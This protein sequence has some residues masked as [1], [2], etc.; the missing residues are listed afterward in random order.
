VIVVR[1]GP[2]RYTPSGYVRTRYA[3]TE[4]DGIAVY[5]PD[6]DEGF[7]IP[8]EDVAGRALVHLRLSPARNG[9]P[10]GVTMADDYRLGA[11]AQLGE[12]CH[13]MAEVVGSIPISSTPPG[14]DASSSAPTRSATASANW[15]QL[16]AGGTDVV[17]TRHGKSYLRLVSEPGASPAA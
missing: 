12:R 2:N 16:A 13:G 3:V 4:V 8:I 14:A 9:Q 17:I 10:A 5:C 15:M 7:Y 6:L 11:V 1:N